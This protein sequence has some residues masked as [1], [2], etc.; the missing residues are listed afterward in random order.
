MSDIYKYKKYKTKLKKLLK[1]VS[2]KNLSRIATNISSE[3]ESESEFQ[4]RSVDWYLFFDLMQVSTDI[5][6]LTN[7]DSYII[8]VGDTPSYLAAFLQE[9]RRVF[10]FAFSNKPFG[11]FWPP[12]SMPYEKTHPIFT[13]PKENL[14]A[15]F[16]YLD[17]KTEL[18]KNFVKNSWHNI[19]LVDSSSGQSICGVSIFFNRYVG[20]IAEEKSEINCENIRKAQPLKFIRLIDTPGPTANIDPKIIE[21]FYPNAGIINYNPK[22]IIN[23]G[24]SFFLHRNLFMINDAYPRIVPFYVHFKW[25]DPPVMNTQILDNLKKLFKTY[26]KI[27]EYTKDQNKELDNRTIE[28]IT[29][30]VNVLAPKF[31]QNIISTNDLIDLNIFLDNISLEVLSQK[32]KYYSS[33]KSPEEKQ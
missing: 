21:K 30:V 24:S 11:C 29:K 19:V 28:S 14:D 13:P 10:N 9:R 33:Y 22:L 3:S 18:T 31:D 27:I 32:Y 6:A 20:N 23:I 2:K 5:V 8:L 26:L 7:V 16:S 4:S 12:Y 15:Y 25:K 17:T 1:S